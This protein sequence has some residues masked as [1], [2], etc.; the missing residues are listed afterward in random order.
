MGVYKICKSGV[1]NL[2]GSNLSLRGALG[3]ILDIL[4]ISNFPYKFTIFS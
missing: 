4:R 2:M 1:R 3:A